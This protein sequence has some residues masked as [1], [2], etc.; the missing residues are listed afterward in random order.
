MVGF[1]ANAV[2]DSLTDVAFAHKKGGL[3]EPPSFG[4][5]PS[6]L[7]Q[8]RSEDSAIRL[9]LPTSSDHGL[10]WFLRHGIKS[11]RLWDWY[12]P[13]RSLYPGRPRAPRDSRTL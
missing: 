2:G 10:D 3:R 12:F 8:E 9:Q 5:T 11:P 13:A 4:A 1:I 7:E 6:A